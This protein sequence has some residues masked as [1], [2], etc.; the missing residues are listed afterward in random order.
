MKST[1]EG[2]VKAHKNVQHARQGGEGWKIE[3]KHLKHPHSREDREDRTQD[4]RNTT[5]RC[6]RHCTSDGTFNT[7]SISFIL[8]ITNPTEFSFRSI[9]ST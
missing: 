3:D 4:T 6:N 8:Q 1:Y 7:D 5:N 9:R 2:Q